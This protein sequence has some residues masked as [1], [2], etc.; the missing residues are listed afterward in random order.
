M[1]KLPETAPHDLRPFV[2]DQLTPKFE[3]YAVPNLLSETH[4]EDSTKSI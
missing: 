1:Q 2:E 3:E 4:G